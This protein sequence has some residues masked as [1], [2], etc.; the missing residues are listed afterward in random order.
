MKGTV[1][2]SA[3]PLTYRQITAFWAPLAGT[4][5]M[6][7]VEGPYLA[8]II[9][10]LEAPAVNLAAFGVAFAFAIIIESPVIMLMSA[11]TAL[12][13]DR[14]SYL[15]LRRFS[16]GLGILL[17][18][19]QLVI[20]VPSVFDF[21]ANLLSLPSE[22][23]SLAHGGLAIMLPW[24]FAIAYRRFKQ[25][26]LIRNGL[27]RRVAY[28][29]GVRLVTMSVTAW[30]VYQR[31]DLPGTLIGALALSIAVV[32]EAVVSRMMTSSIVPDILKRDR[33]AHLLDS[34]HLGALVSFY[35]PLA[36]TSFLVL[37][38]Q[39]TVTFFM[40]QSRLP[41]ESLAVLP[42]VHGLTFIFRAVGL[43][44][45]EV[46]I[47]LIGRDREN[48]VMVRNFA[49][50][51]GLLAFCGLG[52]IA[53]TPLAWFWF[54]DVSGLNRELT[55]VALVPIRILTILPPLSVLLAFERGV[56]VHG[57]KNTSITWATLVELV[58]LAIVL[59]VGIYSL[60]LIGAVAAAV[61]IVA[62]RI[63]STGLMLPACA[64]VLRSHPLPTSGPVAPP[65]SETP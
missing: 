12:A 38:S 48:V 41:V 19:V 13:E 60:D 37:A 53:F 28:G 50:V 46:V 36:L 61:A 5:L 63:V 55:E 43:S 2:T 11:S 9:A 16:Y 62:G 47:A 52:L 7:A 64:A 26:L 59:A 39:P 65:V 33:E 18:L 44:Y 51:L 24:P 29:T 32:A 25:G 22:V 58:C 56:L 17:T 30:V 34:L 20:L 42:V 6:M 57:R 54:R 40:G 3:T 35:M 27:T 45:L 23:A 49:V 4:W 14:E 15:A 10:R 21:I 31:S 8:A 1:G